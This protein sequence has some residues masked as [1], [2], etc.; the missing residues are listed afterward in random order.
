M[1]EPKSYRC[2][3]K[4]PNPFAGGLRTHRRHDTGL[5]VRSASPIN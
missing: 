2:K 5:E 3:P 4:R 1:K